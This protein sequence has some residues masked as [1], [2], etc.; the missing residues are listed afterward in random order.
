MI[1]SYETETAPNTIDKTHARL[2]LAQAFDILGSG[3]GDNTLAYQLLRSVAIS[4]QEHQ[5]LYHPGTQV[6]LEPNP[7]AVSYPEEGLNPVIVLSGIS[8]C[9]KDYL[10][11]QLQK[12]HGSHTV[13]GFGETLAKTVGVDRDQLRYLST[14]ELERHYPAVV[15]TI[16]D[17]QPCI[18][19][20]HPV[21]RQGE[22]W[23]FS[24]M[25][26]NMLNPTAFVIVTAKSPNI[27]MW[28]HQRN[29]KGERVTPLFTSEELD[30]EQEIIVNV[31]EAYSRRRGIGLVTIQNDHRNT[32]QNISFLKDLYRQLKIKEGEK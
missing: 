32:Q 6:L 4:E 8:A 30:M 13:I 5:M 19:T 11:N 21:F 18:V 10:T 26:Y 3:T 16:I 9:G 14:E 28:R 7:E 23:C 1:N 20:S 29:V 25:I 12:E 22:T 24:P 15:Q 17:Q 31:L 27:I 2:L